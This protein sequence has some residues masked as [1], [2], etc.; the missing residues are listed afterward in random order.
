MKQLLKLITIL[1][2]TS[3][4]S[5]CYLINQGS[6]LLKYNFSARPLEEVA[7]DPRTS[8][9]IKDK[10]DL[11]FEIR[12][13]AIEK[14]G[15]KQNKTYTKYVEL[16]GRNYLVNVVVASKKDKLEAYQW[17]F[18]FFGSFPYK[19]F[20][21]F[22]EAK[23]EE[24]RLKEE[25]YDTYIRTAGA[26][27]TLGWF[28]DPIY[29]YM[30][31]YST[32]YLANL[33]IHEMTHAT[34]FIKDNVQFNEEMASFVGDH[35][36]VEFL[37]Y[38]Y[39]ENSNEYKNSFHIKEDNKVFSRYIN[40]F[41]DAMDKMYKNPNLTFE[42][43]MSEKRRIIDEYKY[44]KF[45]DLQNK[46]KLKGSYAWFPKQKLNNALIMGF[47]TYEQDSSLYD[48]VFDKLGK[49]L[50]K[51]ILFFKELEKRS[52]NNPKQFLK[53]FLDDKVKVDL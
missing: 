35:G 1:T 52:G 36:A 17:K 11:V 13:F 3:S 5:S 43:K 45:K 6:N 41:H 16:K 44:D 20:Y 26:F 12:K 33:I 10:I 39:G 50:P 25:G 2:L 4:L 48:K 37:K 22:Q 27:S 15:L 34:V 8:K 23:E 38:K 28:D 21:N 40:E 53:D 9:H 30:L 32:E 47:I 7:K 24:K 18:P 51:T 46:F 42:Q 49:D 14:I 29:S 31:N 19:G